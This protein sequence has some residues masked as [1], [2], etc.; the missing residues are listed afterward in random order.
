M[1]EFRFNLNS[2]IEKIK[3][4]GFDF[5]I[6]RDDLL[7]IQYQG[8]SEEVV[9][10]DWMSA[11]AFSGNKARKLFSYLQGDWSYIKRL[12]S[13]GSAQSNM[14]FSLSVLAQLKGWKFEFYVDHISQHL[15]NNPCGN[16]AAALA[17]GAEIIEL[18][19]AALDGSKSSPGDWAESRSHLPD[20]LFIPEG[21][22]HSASE[23]G[24][25]YLAKELEQ[26]AIE[27]SV[28]NPRVMLPS[29]TG[30]T[31]LY[32]Q[33]HLPFSVLTCACVG[34][35]EYLRQQ[36]NQLSENSDHHPKILSQP[37]GQSSTARKF[38]FGKLYPEFMEIWL[39]L[40]EET[41][42]TFDL[43]YDPL[44]WLS[45]LSFLSS[46]KHDRQDVIYLHQGGLLGNESMLPRYERK[47]P[48]LIR[49]A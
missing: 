2:P 33:K 19:P 41:G 45:L 13:Y 47:F 27:N 14:L 17:Q 38:H 20:T 4:R 46:E 12:V 9:D 44:G 18:P 32:L 30:T 3:F 5:Y 49:P 37:I 31:A 42:I 6:K 40:R 25:Q 29:G 1:N 24:I 28:K 23:A 39:Q 35:E 21:G 8:K 48:Q 36:F 10:Q 43:L 26:W 11:N 16:Y 34:G 7:D 22:R 15:K